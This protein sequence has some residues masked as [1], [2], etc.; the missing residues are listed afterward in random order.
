MVLPKTLIQRITDEK[1]KVFIAGST[2]DNDEKIISPVI[3]EAISIREKLLAII[4]PHEVDAEHIAELKNHFGSDAITLSSI[5]RY[6]NEKIIIVD[7]IGKLFALYRIASFAYIGGGFSSG[8]HNILEPA[9]WGVP[10]IVGPNHERSKEIAAL[11]GLN[12][13]I[14]IRTKEEFED[15][16]ANW[17][18]N[19]MARNLSALAAKDY[20]FHSAGAKERIM[21]KISSIKW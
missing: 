7:S 21:E 15:A 6:Q 2:W 11:I 12:G 9:A 4:V 17:F 18:A 5:D 16:F 19:D 10:S 3:K 13:A 8:V 1:L 14:E 20:V